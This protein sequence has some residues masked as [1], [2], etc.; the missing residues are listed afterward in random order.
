MGEALPIQTMKPL[1]WGLC[2]DSHLGGCSLS[3]AND[4]ALDAVDSTAARAGRMSPSLWPPC[5]QALQS[6]L[7]L[8]GV[9]GR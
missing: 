9:T 2:P 7:T 5:P 3:S 6:L 8:V 1:S 4:H